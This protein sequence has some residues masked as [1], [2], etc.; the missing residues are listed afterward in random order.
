MDFLSFE[1]HRAGLDLAFCLSGKVR[2][3]HGVFV[4]LN[5]ER[6]AA[7]EAA[8]DSAPVAAKLASAV[9]S[10]GESTGRAR[11]HRRPFRTL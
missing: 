3:K 9:K 4:Y 2:K 1:K 7:R 11:R 10:A 8:S 6:D 5:S